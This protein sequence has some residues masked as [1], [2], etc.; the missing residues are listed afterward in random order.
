MWF[1]SKFRQLQAEL[2]TVG[3][4]TQWSNQ[5]CRIVLK[6]SLATRT[7]SIFYEQIFYEV[8]DLQASQVQYLLDIN[9]TS[10]LTSCS[11]A[12]ERSGTSSREQQ[13]MQQ[14]PP[15]IP[16]AKRRNPS[17][18]TVVDPTASCIAKRPM[19][20]LPELGMRFPF[21]WENDCGDRSISQNR[22][23]FARSKGHL[24]FRYTR[25]RTQYFILCMICMH[26]IR[27]TP[28]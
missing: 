15:A 5:L 16:S 7:S 4:S 1:N 3:S 22:K 6:L 2:D 9:F 8:L 26:E 25:T 24:R 13:P 12:E 27:G 14:T 28:T 20:L 18:K 10:G 11:H 23:A 19:S 21:M 17:H